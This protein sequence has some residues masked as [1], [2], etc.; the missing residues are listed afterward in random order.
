LI[1][2]QKNQT[3]SLSNIS[4][5]IQ[6]CIEGNSILR[7]IN[8]SKVIEKKPLASLGISDSDLE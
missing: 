7:E 6:S 3:N 4:E 2:D 5:R 1:G 8:K